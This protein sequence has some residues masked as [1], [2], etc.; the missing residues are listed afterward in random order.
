ME[1][2]NNKL[3]QWQNFFLKRGLQKK[4]TMYNKRV[5][6]LTNPRNVI[7]WGISSIGRAPALHAGGQ[8]FESPILHHKIQDKILSCIL[9]YVECFVSGIQ[10][11]R[12]FDIKYLFCIR[13]F[14]IKYREFDRFSRKLGQKTIIFTPRKFVVKFVYGKI[15]L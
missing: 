3:Y 15:I 9:F 12:N 7:T 14:N 4:F 1:K 5:R 11:I 13:D 6:E 2:N 10:C 8:E